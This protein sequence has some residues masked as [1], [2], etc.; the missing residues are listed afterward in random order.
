MAAL[1]VAE[2]SER[3]ALKLL[4]LDADGVVN[5]AGMKFTR[6][7]PVSPAHIKRVARVVAETG[8]KVVYSTSWRLRKSGLQRFN[9]AFSEHTDVDV[10]S[11]VLGKTRAFAPR[12]AESAKRTWQIRS[13]LDECAA[14]KQSVS[15]WI[16]LDDSDL[17]GEGRDCAAFLEGHFVVCDSSKGITDVEVGLAVKLLS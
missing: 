13:F 2:P 4:F 10:A 17:P 8:C 5:Y 16:A 11:V 12:D 15:H 9:E 3:P 14:K 1:A 7:Y 6:P